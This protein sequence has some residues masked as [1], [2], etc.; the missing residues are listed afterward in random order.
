M[1]QTIFSLLLTMAR[2]CACT[3]NVTC[4]VF[5]LLLSG[6]IHSC[7]CRFGGVGVAKG[8]LFQS[9]L[10]CTVLAEAEQQPL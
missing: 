2:Q 7:A 5:F 9:Q 3:Y 4:I 1:E 8:L 6:I 10:H